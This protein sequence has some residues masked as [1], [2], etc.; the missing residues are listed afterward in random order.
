[1]AVEYTME[2]EKLI[3]D[4]V[5][6]MRQ[7][8]QITGDQF[9]VWVVAAVGRA[10]RIEENHYRCDFDCD[11]CHGGGCGN[12]WCRDDRCEEQDLEYLNITTQFR[13]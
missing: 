1:M 2:L 8:Q 6:A 12:P 7:D 11:N 10:N 3:V 5:V 13:S 9:P 4:L